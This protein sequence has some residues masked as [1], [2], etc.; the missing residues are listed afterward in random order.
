MDGRGLAEGAERS[1]AKGGEWRRPGVQLG[2]LR[3]SLRSVRQSQA[4]HPLRHQT[5]RAN[6][7][8]TGNS[9][10]PPTH[11][12]MK[13]KEGPPCTAPACNVPAPPR[14]F[15]FRVP[16]WWD[17]TETTRPA[18]RAMYPRRLGTQ[19]LVCLDGGMVRRRHVR[20]GAQCTRAASVPNTS[21]ASMGGWYGDDT[22]GPARNVPAPPRY[23]IPRVPRWGDGTETT[24]PAR[25]AMYPRRLGAWRCG[26]AARE[27]GLSWDTICVNWISSAP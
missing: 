19:Y 11:G 16:R 15:L 2:P 18:R 24:R 10:E 13:M 23:P 12:G 3:T 20:P 7:P 25:R 26:A 14:D 22:S 17:G 5:L 21:C 8:L 1:G 6:L 27:R 4:G 9:R